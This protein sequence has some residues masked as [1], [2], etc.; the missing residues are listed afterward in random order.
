MTTRTVYALE[1]DYRDLDN[2]IH[3]LHQTQ[4]EIADEINRRRAARKPTFP[5]QG[6]REG[7]VE[8]ARQIRERQQGKC[9]HGDPVGPPDDPNA[10]KVDGA[11]PWLAVAHGA[12][13]TF[14]GGGGRLW[15]F[16]DEDVEALLAIIRDLIDD[17]I[18]DWWRH[19]YG[20]SVRFVGGTGNRSRCAH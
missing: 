9:I 8:A 16:T 19:D 11:R 4:R 18:A 15:G 20:V 1:Q 12:P 10:V 14:R 7:L 6:Q 17:E 3:Q 2:Q 5:T 13:M